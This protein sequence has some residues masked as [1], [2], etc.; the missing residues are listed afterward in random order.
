MP[1]DPLREVKSILVPVNGTEASYNA[2]AIA[3]DIARRNRAKVSVLYVIEVPRSLPL[4][5]L[6]DEEVEQGEAILQRAEEVADA[7]DIQLEGELLQ[8]RQA[9][10]ALVD[11]AIDTGVDAIVMG[12]DY[13]QPLGRFQLGNVPSYVL[14]QAP[15]EVWMLRYP[16]TELRGRHA[17]AAL[18]SAEEGR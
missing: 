6:L 2:L 7:H 13:H 17:E 3:C 14:A 4:D 1:V 15:C 9:G 16:S 11:E 5:A 12:V 8:A 18:E 10:H